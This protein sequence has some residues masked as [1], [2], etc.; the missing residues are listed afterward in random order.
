MPEDVFISLPGAW[1]LLL[2]RHS[3]IASHRGDVPVTDAGLALAAGVGRRL[4]AREPKLRVLCAETQRS[5]QTAQ[6]IVDGAHSSGSE[7]SGPSIAFGIRNPDIYV[8]GERVELA[9]TAEALAAQVPGVAPEEVSSMP[10]FKGWFS[11]PDRIEW[12]L[13]HANP[14]GEDSATVARRIVSFAASLT[15]RPPGELTVAVTYSP[16]LRACAL[17]LLGVDP[18]EPKWV[19]GLALYVQADRSVRAKILGEPP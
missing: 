6:S 12:W 3:E 13:R 7:V 11:A 1:R 9:S 18:G 5:R 17:E 4:G 14:P 15:D 2:L 10:F 16:V 8:A 19:A